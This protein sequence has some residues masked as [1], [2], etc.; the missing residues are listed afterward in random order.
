MNN[1]FD[2]ALKIE[3]KI[4]SKQTVEFFIN[5]KTKSNQFKPIDEFLYELDISLILILWR[6]KQSSAQYKRWKPE[7]PINPKWKEGWY[8]FRKKLRRQNQKE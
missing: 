1:C 8:M 2:T 7:V 3:N 4:L 6:V 5:S